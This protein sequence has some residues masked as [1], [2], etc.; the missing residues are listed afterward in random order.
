MKIEMG[1]SL[2]Y[3]WLRHVKECQ[4]VQLNWKP[5][6][7]WIIQN[8][9][10]QNEIMNIT[11]PY[12]KERYNY[13]LYGKNSLDQ[14]IKQSEIDVLGISDNDGIKEIFAVDVAFHESGLNY[15]SR[16]ETV[17]RVLKKCIRSAMCI[18]SYFNIEN[19]EIVFASPKI[20]PNVFNELNPKFEEL[21]K[22]FDTL[23]FNVKFSLI[24]NQDFKEKVLDWVI[25]NSEKISDTSEYFLRSYQLYNL[26]N[27]NTFK[28]PLATNL[29]DYSFNEIK[30]GKL[31]R[32]TFQSMMAEEV[33]SDIELQQLTDKKYSKD[34]FDANFPIL[35][36]II[37]DESIDEL[38]YD[39]NNYSRYYAYVYKTRGRKFLLTSEWFARNR[40]FFNDWLIKKQVQKEDEQY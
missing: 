2:L 33:L 19:V 31:V 25:N 28:K 18:Y 22:L 34:T 35:K 14:L 37:K 4:I 32:D 3:S 29:N 11:K 15:G 6:Q 16:K 5:S 1:E 24:A 21:N 20:N 30:I 23:G 39:S 40:T 10:E 38:R 17:Q 9:K 13:D 12:F 27:D 8:Q 26:F 36:E 7:N